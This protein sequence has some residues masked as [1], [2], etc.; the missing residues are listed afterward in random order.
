MLI[1]DL[2]IG[3]Y[4]SFVSESPSDLEFGGRLTSCRHA[5]QHVVARQHPLILI[6][7]ARHR[8]PPTSR[9]L[10]V[11]LVNAARDESLFSIPLAKFDAKKRDVPT[12]TSTEC[13]SRHESLHAFRSQRDQG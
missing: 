5:S 9:S 12:T 3:D 11:L 6:H 13:G 7:H 1:C 4:A 8:F 10:T 2:Q